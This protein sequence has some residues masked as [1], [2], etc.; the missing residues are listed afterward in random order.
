MVIDN[1]HLDSGDNPSNSNN[2]SLPMH[3]PG[4][5]PFTSNSSPA[6]PAIPTDAS[7]VSDSAIQTHSH[8]GDNPSNSDDSSLPTHNPG[9][10]PFNG[11]CSPASPVI[12]TDASPRVSAIQTVQTYLTHQAQ[13][14]QS[15]L[16]TI[17]PGL[18]QGEVCTQCTQLAQEIGEQISSI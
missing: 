2:S 8:T 18:I 7:P 5:I 3:N 12:P 13:A 14:I 15:H 11:N 10:I 6:S 1:S 4:D 16:T 17:L 9:N